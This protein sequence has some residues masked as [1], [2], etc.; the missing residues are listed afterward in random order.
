MSCDCP[1]FG[2]VGGAHAEDCSLWTPQP[3][4]AGERPAPA[5]TRAAGATLPTARTARLTA[6]LERVRVHDPSARLGALEAR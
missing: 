6:L 1:H 4:P 5:D 3:E 2:Y